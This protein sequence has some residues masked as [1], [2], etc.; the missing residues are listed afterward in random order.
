MDRWRVEVCPRRHLRIR[1]P[2]TTILM[3]NYLSIGV[4]ALVT[5]NFHKVLHIKI[6]LLTVQQGQVCLRRHCLRLCGIFNDLTSRPENLL[7]T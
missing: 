4:D 3:N 5:Y 2:R 1:L 6:T 7:S